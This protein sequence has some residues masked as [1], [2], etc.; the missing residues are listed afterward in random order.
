MPKKVIKLQKEY[1]RIMGIDVSS[2]SFAFSIFENGKITHWGEIDLPGDLT[3]RL[4]ALRLRLEALST[5]FGKLD[6]VVMEKAIFVNSTSTASI[7]SQ[8]AGV[9]KS[10]MAEHSDFFEVMPTEWY[11][12]IKNMPKSKK[13]K[14]LFKKNNPG[15]SASWYTAQFR[16]QRKQFTIDWI[17]SEYGLDIESDNKADAIGVGFWLIKTGGKRG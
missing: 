3:Q 2:K 17:K 7:L 13:D 4:V 14:D 11:K 9:T 8:S 1:R 12:V 10:V 16:Q 6:A 15:K 5:V